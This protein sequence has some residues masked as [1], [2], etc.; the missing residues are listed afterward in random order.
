MQNELL[1]DITLLIKKSLSDN[2]NS[3]FVWTVLADETTDASNREQ[4]VIVARY[5]QFVNG[6]YSIKENPMC[7]LDLFQELKSEKASC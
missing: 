5:V 2:I 1:S 6:N 4:M 3:S 7:L